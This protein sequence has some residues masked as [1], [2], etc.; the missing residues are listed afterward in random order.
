MKNTKNLSGLMWRGYIII[1]I[2]ASYGTITFL[3][4]FQER[5]HFL[6]AQLH[7]DTQAE[8]RL[9]ERQ[10]EHDHE[11]ARMRKLRIETVRHM[12]ILT[13]PFHLPFPAVV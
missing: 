10:E 2:I 3:P 6:Q 12:Y 7:N 13:I 8:E 9:C 11:V 4:F 5:N 1:F